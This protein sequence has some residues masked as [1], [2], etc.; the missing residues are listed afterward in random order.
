MTIVCHYCGHASHTMREA[1]RHDAD[2]P[3]SC[4]AC[5]PPLATEAVTSRPEVDPVLQNL[6]NLDVQGERN[7]DR[8][9]D[10]Y[11]RKIEPAYR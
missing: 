7:L 1:A 9:L 11:Y 6:Q 4:L 3:E 10:D 5:R 2:R 8:A